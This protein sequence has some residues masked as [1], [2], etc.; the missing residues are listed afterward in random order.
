[1]LQ[2]LLILIAFLATLVGATTGIGGGIVI[3]VFYDVIGIHSI[4]EIGFYTTVVVFTMSIISIYKQYRGGFN[5]NLNVLLSISLGSVLGGYLGD[6]LLNLFVGDIPK[7]QL[8]IGQSIIL[9]LTLVF[10]LYYTHRKEGGNITFNRSRINIFLLG[11]FLGSISVFLGIGGG[12]LN[13]SLLV[14]FFNYSMKQASV[15]SIATVFFSQITKIIS[16]IG[17]QQYV[18]FDLTLVPWLILVGIVGGYYGTRMNQKL[19]NAAIE[20]VYDVFMISMCALTIFN[21]VRFI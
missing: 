3:K 9:L 12:P 16:I 20:K 13:V 7:T 8:Q 21:I 2:V 11:L 1:M 15:Y 5:Y 6:W 4:L 17:T 14:I 19:S 10:L 18:Q